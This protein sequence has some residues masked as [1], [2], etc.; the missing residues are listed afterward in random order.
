MDFGD[1]VLVEMK[2]HGVSNEKYL[3][4]VIGCLESNTYVP[5]PVQSPAKE[6]IHTEIVPVIQC[7]CCGIDEREV[8]KYRLSDVKKVAQENG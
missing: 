3:H 2:R 1:Y 7:I 8:L 6:V 4:K 5:V